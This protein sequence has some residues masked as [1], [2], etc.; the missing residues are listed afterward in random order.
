M[1][2]GNVVCLKLMSGEELIGTKVADECNDCQV[3]IKDVAS[4]IMM[5]GGGNGQQYGLG[6]A[7]FLGY[8]ESTMFKLSRSA[9]VIEHDPSVDMINNYNR[10]FGAGIQVV[11]SLNG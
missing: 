11:Q 2:V 8:S 3:A 5:P 9:V 1:N 10:M 6:L 4:I 7:P